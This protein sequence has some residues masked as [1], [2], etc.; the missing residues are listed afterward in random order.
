M[1]K[2]AYICSIRTH[3]NK[4]TF[5]QLNKTELSSKFPPT[6]TELNP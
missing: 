5:I 1:R 6:K 2:D 3:K 4:N